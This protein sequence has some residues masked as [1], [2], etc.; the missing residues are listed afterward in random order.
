M[1]IEQVAKRLQTKP[2]ILERESLRLY[3]KKLRVIES[4]LLLLAHKYGVK[5]VTELDEMIKQG[6]YH[7]DE[8][9]EDYFNFD[10]LEHERDEILR[11]LEE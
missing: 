11:M 3:L 5:N 10:Y 7:E 9:F 4:E 2:E 6:K 1:L 8:A